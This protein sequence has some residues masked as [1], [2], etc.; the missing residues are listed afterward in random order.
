M[1]P[2]IKGGVTA[3]PKVRADINSVRIV[4]SGGEAKLQQKSVTPSEQQQNVFP[5]LGYDGLSKVSVGA[6]PA[7]YVGPEVPEAEATTYYPT[8][9]DQTIAAGQYLSGAQT[10]R[11]VGQNNLSAANIKDGVTVRVGAGEFLP[12]QL[13]HP[14][15][16]VEGSFT[17]VAGSDAATP[18]DVRNG[19]KFFVNG[20]EYIGAYEAESLH[21]DTATA[22]SANGST[23]V[24][25]GLDAEPEIFFVTIDPAYAD[26]RTTAVMYDG[27]TV[28][29]VKGNRVYSA[30]TVSYSNGTLTITGGSTDFDAT[31]TY[32]LTYGY[33]A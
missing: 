6:I 12:E 28:Y 27:T 32:T 8:G 18:A 29:N 16:S 14:I 33:T 25:T 24:F 23:L 2:E 3:R 20:N 4:T 17:H 7:D 13:A 22:T 30:M 9:S 31:Y 15:F 19:K 26:R 11:R 21:I 1:I 10:I 5:D